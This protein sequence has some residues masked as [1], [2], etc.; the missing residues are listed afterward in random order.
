M[1][2]NK[3]IFSIFSC[4]LPTVYYL[5][6][7]VCCLL[8]LLLP[9]CGKKGDPTLKSYE[10]P[11]APSGLTAI[12]RESEIIISWEFPKTKEQGLKGFHLL[13]SS[14]GDFQ[15]IAFIAKEKRSHKDSNFATG[16]EYHYKIISESLRGI[17]NDSIILSIKPVIPPSPPRKLTFS[18]HHETLDLSWERVD[19]KSTYNIYKSTQK[20]TYSLVPLNA[21]PLK[22]PSFK[23]SF[24]INQTVFYTVRSST[25]SRIRDE[26]PLSEDLT[27]NPLEFIPSSPQNL[28]AVPTSENVYLLWKEPP[29]TWVSGYRVYREMSKQEGYVF[30][31]FTHTP[32]YADNGSTIEKRNYRVTALGPA[33]EGPPAEIRDVVYE[34]PR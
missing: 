24:D 28:E 30:I 2:K 21:Q 15:S 31:G 32:S 3:H 5:L 29:E 26:G 34:L 12:H 16:E 6:S 10:K 27:V 8:F 9:A 18:V 20:G 14:A 11:E 4:L 25:G 23:D 7:I 22:K 17:T 1:I 13:K 19:E 33:K